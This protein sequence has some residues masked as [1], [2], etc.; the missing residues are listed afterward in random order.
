VRDPL[1]KSLRVAA[2]LMLLRAALLVPVA[3]LCVLFVP[4][5]DLGTPAPDWEPRPAWYLWVA[6]GPVVAIALDAVGLVLLSRR[7]RRA[8]WHIRL[9]FLAQILALSFLGPLV[10]LLAA[11][12]AGVMVSVE[13]PP[14]RAWFARLGTGHG[15]AGEPR[16]ESAQAV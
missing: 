16:D 11:L 12:G 4:W 6:L 7:S 15:G 1:P 2:A 3:I 13:G 10:L 8:L 14:A 9:T 5:P